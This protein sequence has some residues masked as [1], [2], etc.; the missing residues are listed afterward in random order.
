METDKKKSVAIKAAA[1]LLIAAAAI[2]GITSR[3][4]GGNPD[5]IAERG[6]A[7]SE[8]K[9]PDLN[10]HDWKLTDYRGKVVLLN[11]WATWCPP[12]RSETPGLVRLAQTNAARGVQVVGIAMDEDGADPVRKF[13]GAYKVPYPILLP[14][15][16]SSLF[17]AVSSLP[18]TLLI[19]KYG[20]VAKRYMGAVSEAQ[21]Q[22]DIDR[23]LSV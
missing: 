10:G 21:F 17:S 19:D 11:F 12:C 1:F 6:K 13:V 3:N 22:R 15:E 4:G 16:N 8:F 5:P 7:I 9:L 2:V 23:V 20:K 18:T 14:P